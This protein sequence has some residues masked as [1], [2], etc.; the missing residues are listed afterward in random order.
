MLEEKSVLC[1]AE[2]NE[3]SEMSRPILKD[4][5]QYKSYN[6]LSQDICQKAC[7][8]LICF[9]SLVCKIDCN[10]RFLKIYIL[11]S[12]YLCL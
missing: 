6:I 11:F 2:N 12:T 1:V 4:T 9:R 5:K 7:L 8:G 3:N 10:N